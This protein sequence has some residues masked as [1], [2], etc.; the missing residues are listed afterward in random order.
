M[1]ALTRSSARWNA[2]LLLASIALGILVLEGAARSPQEWRA[3]YGWTAEGAGELIDVGDG[4][5]VRMQTGS[6]DERL[7]A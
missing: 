5:R 6:H 3:P 7:T 1:N 4:H 2:L